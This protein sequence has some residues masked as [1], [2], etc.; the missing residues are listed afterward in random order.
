[1]ETLQR[2]TTFTLSVLVLLSFAFGAVAQE[3]AAPQNTANGAPAEGASAPESRVMT[4]E[5]MLERVNIILKNR[6][7]IREAVPGV[8]IVGEGED[9]YVEFNGIRAEDLSDEALKILVGAVNQQVSLRN[10]ENIERTQKQLRQLK[11]IQNLNKQQ[12]QLK[13]IRNPVPKI[14][15]VPKTYRPPK[16][17]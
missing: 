3:E 10:I 4:R 13:Q 17:Y 15:K 5:D 12:R 16:K 6:T 8:V 11:Q 9:S 7:D 2:L 14:P 1:M